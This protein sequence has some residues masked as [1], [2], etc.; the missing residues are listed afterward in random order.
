[1]FGH[2]VAHKSCFSESEVLKSVLQKNFH[3]TIKLFEVGQVECNWWFWDCKN[4][5]WVMLQIVSI[6]LV[7]DLQSLARTFETLK[8]VSGAN[9]M[10]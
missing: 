9:F 2:L 8:N 4:S 1:M 7:W 6:T 5:F 10:M 3:D